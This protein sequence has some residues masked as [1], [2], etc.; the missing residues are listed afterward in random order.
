MAIN[1]NATVEVSTIARS[2]TA[3]VFSLDEKNNRI[4]ATELKLKLN[5]SL[6]GKQSSRKY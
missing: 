1:W 2:V 4:S 3:V 5:L 6:I